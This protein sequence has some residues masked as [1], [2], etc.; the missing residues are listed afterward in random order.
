[1]SRYLDIVRKA[2]CEAANC[3][4]SETA[5]HSLNSQFASSQGRLALT[6]VA[7]EARCPDL[8]EVPRW[9]LAIADG[10]A[11]LAKWGTQAEALGWSARDL[12]GLLPVP[13]HA[14]PG[15][16]RLSRYDETGLVWLLQGRRV[17]AMTETTAAIEHPSGSITVYRRFHKPA[18]GPL[19]DSLGDLIC[20]GPPTVYR[21]LN[22]PG[23][24]PGGDSL[25]DLE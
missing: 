21:R 3:E 14:E 7:L 16:R 19:G 22:R 24:R 2:T 12:F 20:G 18:L 4:K 1:M 23:T 8:L 15:F 25:E 6:L 5:D 9:Q 11:F 10:K 13:A 17:V